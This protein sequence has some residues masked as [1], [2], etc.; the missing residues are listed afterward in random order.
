MYL[1]ENLY[2]QVDFESLCIKLLSMNQ[3]A[4]GY[5]MVTPRGSERKFFLPHS[6]G[7]ALL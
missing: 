7:L 4:T 1:L 6:A 3:R 5:Q 2:N